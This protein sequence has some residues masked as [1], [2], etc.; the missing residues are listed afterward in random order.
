MVIL[1]RFIFYGALFA[2][3]YCIATLL[4]AFEAKFIVS[5]MR[6]IAALV[7]A[8]LVM[9]FSMAS[10]ARELEK[11]EDLPFRSAERLSRKITIRLAVVKIRWIVAFVSGVLLAGMSLYF[12]Y[13]GTQPAATWL[14]ATVIMLV[15]V[16]VL[17]TV[18]T[19]LEFFHIIDLERKLR[20]SIQQIKTKKKFWVDE[21]KNE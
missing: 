18:L 21:E 6:W 12:A 16:G 3:C 20:I 11:I 15:L 5:G 13:L 8:P 17:F 19:G 14:I 9:L 7:G 1:T 2:V 4:P 10:K